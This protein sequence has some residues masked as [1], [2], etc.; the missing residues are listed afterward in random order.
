M[1]NN[2]SK[3]K[4]DKK[5]KKNLEKIELFASYISKYIDSFENKDD[6][7]S[8]LEK[9]E[10]MKNTYYPSHN[11]NIYSNETCIT[12][13]NSLDENDFKTFQKY[14]INKKNEKNLEQDCYNKLQELIKDF[15]IDIIQF[16]VYSKNYYGIKVQVLDNVYLFDFEGTLKK[17]AKTL[18]EEYNE[19]SEHKLYCPY[20]NEEIK[21][22]EYQNKCE[23]GVDIIYEVSKPNEISHL[24]EEAGGKEEIKHNGWKVWFLDDESMKKFEII[25]ADPNKYFNDKFDE[26]VKNTEYEH[27][28]S[29]SI[30]DKK[31][32]V[33]GLEFTITRSDYFKYISKICLKYCDWVRNGSLYDINHDNDP[34]YDHSGKLEIIS[35]GNMYKNITSF[36]TVD[37]WIHDCYNGN[38]KPTFCSGRGFSHS[39]FNDYIREYMSFEHIIY[40]KLNTKKGEDLYEE[41]LFSDEAYDIGVEIETVVFD[42]L[43]KMSTLQCWN[44]WSEYK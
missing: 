2:K 19:I 14:F 24:V 10:N 39:T 16:A 43:E 21:T 42:Y 27:I 32:V 18:I 12:F 7:I 26:Y 33:N 3:N 9:L 17:L 15:D 11:I 36:E 8:K 22:S 1:K 4:E 23:C 40:E 37:N 25:T 41:L 13:I 34:Y 28:N 29:D 5:I 31:Y 20:C 6:L 35:E 44:D 38:K 30:I